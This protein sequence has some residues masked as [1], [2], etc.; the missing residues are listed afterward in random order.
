MG[1]EGQNVNSRKE[2]IW[3]NLDRA[4]QVAAVLVLRPGSPE[5]GLVEVKDWVGDKLP[6]YQ[7]PREV[8]WL[9]LYSVCVEH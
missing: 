7:S 9:K 3:T 5:M 4:F 1:S 6:S 8:R 2:K